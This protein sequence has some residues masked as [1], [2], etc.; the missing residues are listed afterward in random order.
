MVTG[1]EFDR[2]MEIWYIP[3]AHQRFRDKNKMPGWQYVLELWEKGQFW[4]ISDKCYPWRFDFEGTRREI[5]YEWENAWDPEIVGAMS[6]DPNW[7]DQVYS[8]LPQW[9]TVF[10]QRWENEMRIL[11][12]ALTR[13]YPR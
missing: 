3:D 2:Q 7:L 12:T 9:N 13:Y 8:R 11:E 10:N 5:V 1:P 4:D 6:T